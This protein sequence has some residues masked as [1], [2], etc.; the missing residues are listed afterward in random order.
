MGPSQPIAI[1][2]A[3]VRHKGHV[4][5]GRRPSG[6]PLAGFWEF[7]GGKV[8]P[9]E[10]GEEAAVR[11]CFEETGLRIRVSRMETEVAHRY[12]FGAVAIRF[13]AAE[14]ADP[15]STPTGPFRWV[16]IADLPEY[17]F[18]PANEAILDRLRGEC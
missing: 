15:S 16:R 4:L 5:I 12:D 17:R 18:P 3:V 10:S 13:F 14:P 9:G 2:V 7:P 8:R 11:E 1:A 6:T